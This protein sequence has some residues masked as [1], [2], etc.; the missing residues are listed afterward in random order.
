MAQ[1]KYDV[2]DVEAGGGGEE[3]QPGLYPGKIVGIT[4]RATKKN[5]SDKV[6][7][8]EVVVDIGKEYV[9]MY[10]Y[11]KLPGDPAFDNQKWKLRE[12]TDALGLPPKGALPEL[13]TLSG[14]A[15]NV[16]VSADTDRDGGY[17]GRIKNLF[18]PTTDAPAGSSN[19]DEPDG[20]GDEGPYGREEIETWSDEDL[21]GYAEELGVE[22]PTGRGWKVKLIDALIMAEA[23]GDEPDG[24]SDGEEAA[25]SGNASLLE[26]LSDELIAELKTDSDYYADWSDDDVKGF[27]T[28]LGI[29][30]NVAT[31]GRGWRPKAV[32]GIVEFAEQALGG[33]PGTAGEAAAEEDTYEDE[34]EWPTNDLK[35]EIEER[36]EQGAEITIEG[37]W[38]RAKMIAALREDDKSAAPF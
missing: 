6:N 35:A 34:G 32:A 17:R 31:S 29:D 1:I 10:T 19:G 8:L 24:E 7:D 18:L 5:S 16:K 15:V 12:F 14:K 25:S 3:P 9:R 36:N 38:T 21:K 20:S 37:R 23:E 33:E 26:G 22:V 28:D 13:K 2:S 27:V 4:Q 11:I 30:G